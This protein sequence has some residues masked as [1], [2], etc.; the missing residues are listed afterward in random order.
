M[1][2]AC[3]ILAL[4]LCKYLHFICANF[5]SG[6]GTKKNEMAKGGVWKTKRKRENEW[7]MMIKN[8]IGNPVSTFISCIDEVALHSMSWISKELGPL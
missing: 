7:L 1:M 6:M 4:H 2:F 3:F 5:G 8:E